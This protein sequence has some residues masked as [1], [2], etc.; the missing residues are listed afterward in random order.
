MMKKILL[1][2][3]AFLLVFYTL[4]FDFSGDFT[5]KTADG[6]VWT[7][8]IENVFF[9]W[10]LGKD[11]ASVNFYKSENDSRYIRRVLC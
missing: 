6:T 3:N 5:E 4:A 8:T 9:G 10:Q 11:K 1:I 7:Y 2:A